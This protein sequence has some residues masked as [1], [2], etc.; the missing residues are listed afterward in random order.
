ME[1]KMLSDLE[2]SIQEE[3]VQKFDA[4]CVR[5]KSNIGKTNKSQMFDSLRFNSKTLLNEMG[6]RSPKLTALLKKIHDLDSADMK[7]HGKLFKHFIFSDLKMNSAGAK[8]ISSA[9]ISKGL[10]LGYGAKLKKG[11]KTDEEET[12]DEEEDEYEEDER[13]PLN[14]V[15]LGKIKKGGAKA[16]KIY[17]KIEF[18]SNQEL[19]KTKNNNFYL[20]C[21][22]G[23][24][25]QPISV[26]MKKEILKR[27]NERPENSHGE[28]VRFIVMDSGYKEGID[29]FD[30][31]YIH[32]F[33]PAPIMADQKQIIGRG[34]RTCGQKGLDFH[35]RRGWP[36]KVFVYDLEI[37]SAL[38]HGLNGSHSGLELYL[39]AMN[40]D[41]R[42]LNF[43]HDLEKSTVFGSVDYELNKN[44]HMFSIPNEDDEEVLPDGAEFTYGGVTKR[45]TLRLRRD[46]PPL[47]VNN[48]I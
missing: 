44:V 17:E 34:T 32:I 30:I 25:D 19:E 13:T 9:L 23:V 38:Q 16:K 18:L 36:L 27:F 26:S 15:S 2:N 41:V 48:E 8:L 40:M 42:L 29:L 39:K 21:S 1:Q 10:T 28:R 46:L 24:Y 37:P 6:S 43:A 45:R 47:I 12:S 20:L 35:P 3:V 33:E 11:V 5:K 14:L 7:K 4:T 22:S 31:K